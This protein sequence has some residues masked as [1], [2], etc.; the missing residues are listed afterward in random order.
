[1]EIAR[2]LTP[3]EFADRDWPES[4]LADRDQRDKTQP[5][6][7]TVAQVPQDFGAVE[8]VYDEDVPF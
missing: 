7:P 8:G 4:L 1:M 2:Y 5:Q 6:S 3:Q